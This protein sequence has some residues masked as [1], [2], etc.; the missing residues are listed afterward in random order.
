MTCAHH[1]HKVDGSI[2]DYCSYYIKSTLLVLL[3]RISPLGFDQPKVL[4][5]RR[6]SGVPKQLD[7]R[8][9]ALFQQIMAQCRR[10]RKR[11]AQ[12]TVRRLASELAKTENYLSAVENGR[13]FPS[14]RM[15]LEYLVVVGF[16]VSPLTQL[17]I[18]S[19]F[20]RPAATEKARDELIEKIYTLREHQVS[21]LLKQA[22]AVKGY[23][24]RPTPSRKK[25][26]GTQR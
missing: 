26:K 9:R 24:V 25:R 10:E 18:D 23:A 7:E 2:V 6:G 1:L 22:D 20:K 14:L 4:E 3:P 8:V 16:D 17:S 13:E 12:I 21:L 11:R 15:F 19:S 5:I